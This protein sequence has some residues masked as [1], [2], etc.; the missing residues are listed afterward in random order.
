MG[1]PGQ[2]GGTHSARRGCEVMGLESSSP[3]EHLLMEQPDP[4]SPSTSLSR[5]GEES[6]RGF[7]LSRKHEF[8]QA[9]WMPGKYQSLSGLARAREPQRQA[10]EG[11]DEG[12]GVKAGLPK[13]GTVVRRC[14]NDHHHGQLYVQ[15][16]SSGND[17]G[18]P[19]L[20]RRCGHIDGKQG[21]GSG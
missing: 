4:S 12:P 17:L 10:A 13:G 21:H 6:R 3:L 7:L 14:G 1:S 11:G 2:C 16:G 19:Y 9:K 8:P 5:A 20:L 18:S 15:D